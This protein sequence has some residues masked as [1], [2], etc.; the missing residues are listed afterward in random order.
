MGLFD[1]LKPDA[2][3]LEKLLREAQDLCDSDQW[4][5]ALPVLLKAAKSLPGHPGLLFNIA[6]CHLRRGRWGEA[7]KALRTCARLRPDDSDTLHNLGV[8]CM[9]LDLHAE[10]VE[11]FEKAVRCDPAFDKA[12]FNLATTYDKLKRYGDAVREFR[13]VFKTNP[14]RV[15]AL[16]GAGLSLGRD[17]KRA[18]SIDFNH[19]EKYEEQLIGATYIKNHFGP[20]PVEFVA[21]IKD[22]VGKGEIEAIKAK[23][24]NHEMRKYLPVRTPDLSK[25]SAQEMATIDDVLNKLSDMKAVANFN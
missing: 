23:F 20:T 2:K 14:A 10:A 24:F 21:V 16:I 18:E 7:A 9:K 17:G 8:A 5:A 25:L 6:Q 3:P 1:F 15:D 13:G 12:R 4:D 22:M 19:Y 11:A